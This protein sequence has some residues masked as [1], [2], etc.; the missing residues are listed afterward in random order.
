MR[1]P[2][3]TDRAWQE[4]GR[5]DPYFAVLTDQALHQTRL[6]PQALTAFFHSGEV[7]IGGV[8]DTIRRHLDPAFRPGRALDFGTGVGRLLFPLA[9]VADTVVGVD[10]SSAMLAEAQKHVEARG[11]S[12]VTLVQSDDALS[13]VA[14]SFDLVHSFLVLQHVPVARGERLIRRLVELLA[15]GGV[16]ALHVPYARAASPLRQVATWLRLSVPGA[17]GLLNRLR[18]APWRQPPM[19]MNVYELGRLYGL[20]ETSGIA[21]VHARFTRDGDYRGVMLYAQKAGPSTLP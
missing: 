16:A 19:Q 13:H 17:H 7:H 10:V 12:N 3:S 21:H 9:A 8:L 2:F 20:F 14:G 5:Q 6:T 11:L 1:S 18:G 15:P 4:W